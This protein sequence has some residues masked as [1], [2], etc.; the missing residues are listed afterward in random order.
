MFGAISF[1]PLYL[2][3]A[4][5]VSP[6]NS[7]LLLVPLMLG[8]LAASIFAGQVITRT[9]RYRVLPITGTGVATLGMFLLSTL[10]PSTP[11]VVSGLFM[12]VLGIGLGL[13]MQVLVLATQNSVRVADLGVATSTVNFFRSVGGSVGVAL[14]GALFNSRLVTELAGSGVPAP[15]P[16]T[17]TAIAALPTAEK[18]T[19]VAG[20]S[21]ALTG[22]FLIG[23]PVIGIGFLLSFLLREIPLRSTSGNARA[24]AEQEVAAETAEAQVA[25]AS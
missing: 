16:I 3:V 6:T 20:F 11:R 1:L 15:D 12:A 22:V 18:A 8:L 17:P 25:I 21:D 23:V 10:E 13:S 7:G 19:F 5:G 9:G 2:Q 14:F 24:L 4:G